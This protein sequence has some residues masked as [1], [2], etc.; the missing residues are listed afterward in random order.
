MLG[1]SRRLVL[2]GI[3]VL[4]CLLA[5]GLGT[6]AGRR[7]RT[8]APE[9]P[10]P[11][12]TVE[13]LSVDAAPLDLGDVW[14]EDAYVHTISI[15]NDNPNPVEV[16]RFFVSC[17]CAGVEPQTVSLAPGETADVRL[18]LDLA[19]RTLNEVGRASRPFTVSLG[20]LLKSS[21][22]MMPGGGWELRAVIKSRVTL[23]KLSLHFGDE[24][25]Q[26][27]SPLTRK[28]RATVHLPGSSLR[29][30]AADNLVSWKVE[31]CAEGADEFDVAVSTN[32]V[33]LK[34][35]P[36]KTTLNVEVATAEGHVLPGV[37]LPVAGTVRLEV[38]PVPASVLL[39]VRRIGQTAEATVAL[40]MPPGEKWEVERIE[41]D[42]PDVQV[43]SVPAGAAGGKAYRLRVRITKER[44]QASE[45]RFFVR[46]PGRDT[47]PVA[48]TVS[49]DGDAAGVLS[50]DDKA[51]SE[52]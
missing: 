21:G 7:I 44:P 12:V 35:G 30:S 16:T 43:D 5:L 15:R 42:S 2:A 39:G 48:M 34:A 24:P 18:K 31:P 6:V 38:R 23:D 22:T 51:R 3:M 1:K 52:P 49:Y 10:A 27:A 45:V 41:V 17:G 46:K 20:P 13:G 29:V 32:P 33:A 9:A 26:N 25:I 50:G 47:A 14:E 40:Q 19:R 8:D 37:K 11:R 4:T 28:V 36:F